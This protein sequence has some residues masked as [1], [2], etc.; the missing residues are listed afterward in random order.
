MIYHLMN[1][2]T[3]SNHKIALSSRQPVSSH[4]S[5]RVELISTHPQSMTSCWFDRLSVVQRVKFEHFPRGK[6]ETSVLRSTSEVQR[7]YKGV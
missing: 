6:S 5:H 7:E 3:L 1:R 2:L 4:L